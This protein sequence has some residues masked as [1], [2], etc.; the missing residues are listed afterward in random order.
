MNN[1]KPSAG[2]IARLICLVLSTVNQI[3]LMKTGKSFL[4][5]ESEQLEDALSTILFVAAA[6]WSYWENN[7]WTKEA[8]EADDTL[9]LMKKNK[10]T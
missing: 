9:H 1:K 10:R 8:I 6:G 5:V 7:S 3:V 2:T 4:P